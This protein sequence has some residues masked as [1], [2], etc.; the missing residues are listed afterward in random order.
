M[1]NES[2]EFREKLGRISRKWISDGLPSRQKLES[3]AEAL[4]QWKRDQQVSGIWPN[5]P[6]MLTGTIDDGI[7]QG[8]QIIE[9]YAKVMGLQVHRLGLLLNPDTIIYQCRQLQPDILGLTILQLDSDDALYKVGH[10]LPSKTRLITGGS[11]FKSDPDMAS[12]CHVNY[13]ASNVAF[14]INDLLKWK[15]IGWEIGR[16]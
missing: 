8:I 2:D 1:N 7:G 3:T 6:L 9:C 4:A 14:F 12:R 10:N 13:V 11:V 15:T 16:S 5:R